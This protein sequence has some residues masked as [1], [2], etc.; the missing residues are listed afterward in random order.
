M[1]LLSG[2]AFISGA[3]NLRLMHKELRWALFL[4]SSVIYLIAK[5]RDGDR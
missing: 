4:M 1:H 2:L 3:E 5:K